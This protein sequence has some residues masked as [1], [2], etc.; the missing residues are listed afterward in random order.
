M[1]SSGASTSMREQ[2]YLALLGIF[3]TTVFLFT[4]CP[5][6]RYWDSAELVSAAHTLGI[7]HAPGFPLYIVMGRAAKTL[8]EWDIAYIMSLSSALCAGIGVY[9]LLL[10]LKKWNNRL[11]WGTILAGLLTAFAGGLW[12]QANRA[13]VYA[14]SF[15]LIVLVFYLIIRHNG[16]GCRKFLLA[17]GYFWGLAA[18]NHTSS[19][20]AVLIPLLALIIRD[21]KETGFRYWLAIYPIAGAMLGLSIYLMIPIRSALQPEINWGGVH[22]WPS[23]F[24]LISAKDFAFSIKWNGWLDFSGRL[25]LHW[26]LL[27]QNIPLPLTLFTVMGFW[28]M[29]YQWWV[30][31]LF[32]CGSSVTLMR[33]ALPQ[34]DHLGYL[35][36]VILALSIWTCAGFDG[37]FDWF[38][39]KGIFSGRWAG[40][41][42]QGGITLAVILPMFLIQLEKNNLRSNYNAEIFG[43]E[44]IGKLPDDSIVMFNDI[45]SYFICR[46]LQV[47]KDERKDCD[48]ILP[49][50]L[51]EGGASREWYAR[52]IYQRTEIPGLDPLPSSNLEVIAKIIENNHEFRPIYC[53]YGENYRPF[54]KYLQPE[55]MLFKFVLNIEIE[56]DKSVM[57]FTG[58][59]FS[60]DIET[61]EFYASRLYALSLYYQDTGEWNK[62][63]KLMKEAERMVNKH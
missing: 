49:G 58:K 44:I 25:Y 19:A 54:Y 40:R 50:M 5:T 16:T 57:N 28:F 39:S 33:E 7:A 9:F 11:S 42:V 30:L 38:K 18:A 3:I 21:R 34:P 29:R 41:I 14:L 62:A 46:Y 43:R 13:E 23:F 24:H 22:N 37:V 6:V 51:I 2:S 12:I 31:L 10:L 56:P 53:E 32:V 52:E 61:T 60:N 26:K 17:S 8:I 55:G 15:L 36:P 59:S 4:A 35:L 48:L 20:A 63:E 47:V 45:S 27:Y 1:K